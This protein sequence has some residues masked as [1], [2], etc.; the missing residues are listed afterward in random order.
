[1][2]E[3]SQKFWDE[4]AERQKK[5]DARIDRLKSVLAMREGGMMFKQIAEHLSVSTT[6]VEQLFRDASRMR[7]WDRLK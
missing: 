3:E 6:R 2:N 4:R 7:K 5:H 1:M